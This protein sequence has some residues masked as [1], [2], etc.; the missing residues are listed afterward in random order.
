MCRHRSGVSLLARAGWPASFVD[1]HG[2]LRDEGQCVAQDRV[3][4]F[5]RRAPCLT[6]QRQQPRALLCSHW[7][8]QDWNPTCPQGGQ[9][10]SPS[11]L[12]AHALGKP[13]AR[14]RQGAFQGRIQDSHSA[15][16]CCRL[17]EWPSAQPCLSKALPDPKTVPFVNGVQR[18]PASGAT[19]SRSFH[20][21]VWVPLRAEGLCTGEGT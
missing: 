6:E 8:C 15:H 1:V 21:C 4:A 14:P 16:R 19:C 2:W 3:A 12:S 7:P 20:Q 10:T 17:N 5:W 11:S 9:P 18:S 13:W